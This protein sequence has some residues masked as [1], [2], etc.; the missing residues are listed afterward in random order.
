MLPRAAFPSQR[1]HP[2]HLIPRP[3]PMPTL[4]EAFILLHGLP[5]HARDVAFPCLAALGRFAIAH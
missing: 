5:L 1:S 4:H 2:R 3:I